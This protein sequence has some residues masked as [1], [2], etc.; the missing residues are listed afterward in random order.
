MITTLSDLAPAARIAAE[1]WIDDAVAD[2]SPELRDDVADDLRAA[3]ALTLDPDATPDDVAAAVDAIGP[4]GED[5]IPEGAGDPLVGTLG[6]VP[7]DLHPPS[8]ERIASRLWNPALEQVFVPRAFGLGWDLNFAAIAV[9]LGLIEPDAEDVPFTS[10]PDWAFA[11]ASVLP[12]KLAALHYAVRGRSLPER[13]PSHWDLRGR[14]DRW[15]SRQRAAA[16]DLVVSA[17]AVGASG[18]AAVGVGSRPGR[19]GLLATASAAAT[20]AASITLLRSASPRPRWWAGPALVVG[21]AGAAG[22]TLLG[23]ALAGRSAEQ[24]ADASG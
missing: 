16:T 20:F 1:G 14:P 17:L 4:V 6:G 11:A 13:L 18:A 8:A 21:I 22:G 7:Y 19:A 15:T 5:G 12:L 9:R 24:H 10:T 3:L 2:L 23:L